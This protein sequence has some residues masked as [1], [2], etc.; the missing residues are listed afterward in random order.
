MTSWTAVYWGPVVEA[1]VVLASLRAAGVPAELVYQSTAAGA[2]PAPGPT[3][4]RVVVPNDYVQ[5]ATELILR[6][7]KKQRD[8]GATTATRP[9]SPSIQSLALRAVAVLFLAGI[10]WSLVNMMVPGV[11]RWWAWPI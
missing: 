8:L 9:K 5:P 2:V 3:D 4:S 11:S 6:A 1:D 7:G 10:L